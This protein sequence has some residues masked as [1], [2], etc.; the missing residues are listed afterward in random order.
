[1]G[2]LGVG[3]AITAAPGP[4]PIGCR[5][6]LFAS[7]PEGQKPFCTRS[8]DSLGQPQLQRFVGS[9]SRTGGGP[10]P[11]RQLSLTR[12]LPEPT[13]FVL[14]EGVEDVGIGASGVE[15]PVFEPL[16]LPEPLPG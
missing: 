2:G 13:F 7:G 8:P 12:P 3:G 6:R 10:P 16:P 5:R 14:F 11:V 4:M 9:G 1:M 15:C